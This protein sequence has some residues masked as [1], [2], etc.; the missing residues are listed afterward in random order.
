MDEALHARVLR[1]RAE[2][3]R[4][5]ADLRAK[6]RVERGLVD[7]A[8]PRRCVDVRVELHDVI[9]SLV[10]LAEQHVDAGLEA[11]VDLDVAAVEDGFARWHVHLVVGR[12]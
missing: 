8:R 5:E 4:A 3:Q 12:V 10:V 7:V 11:F 1:L 9:G 6:E 2:V